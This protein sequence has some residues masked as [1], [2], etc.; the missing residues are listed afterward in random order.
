MRHLLPIGLLP[1]LALLA[2]PLSAQQPDFDAAHAEAL[3]LLGDLVRIDTSSPPGNETDAARYIQGV[4]AREG[5]ESQIYEREPGRGNLVARLKGNGSKRPILL[6]GHLDVVGVEPEAWTEEAFGG[7]IKEGYLYGRG[8]QD[9]KGMVAVAL[10]V[11]LL[12]HRSGVELDRDVIL[13][14]N[15]G[16]EG[17]PGLGVQFMIDEHFPEIDAEFALNEGGGILQQNGRWV[18]SVATTEKVSRGMRLIAH[19]TSGHGSRPLPD[20]PIVHLGAAVGKLGSWQYPMRLSETTREY[21]RRMAEVVEPERADLYRNLE[22]PDRTAEVQEKLRLTDF[23]A[24]SLLRTSISPTIIEGG[25]RSNVIPA[26]ASVRLDIRALPEDDPAWLV[27][28]L[29]RVIDDPAIEITPP[30]RGRPVSP[31]MPM[32]SDMFRALVTAQAAVF[33]GGLVV[34]TMVTGA[35]DSAQLRA[36]GVKAYG[37]GGVTDAATGSRAHGN[38]ERTPVEGVGMFVRFLYRA[39]TEVAGS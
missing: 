4:L 13:M 20:N 25:F 11:F 30:G 22:N 17:N 21:F 36:Q 27:S 26:E 16:E 8:S 34:P 35:T 3:Q 15:A 2:G 1:A 31:P 38:D 29:A 14:A 12:L 24:N 23:T 32:D 10:E 6:M 18:V 28:E 37:I 9:D 19:G 7:V 39:V 5:I 33:P